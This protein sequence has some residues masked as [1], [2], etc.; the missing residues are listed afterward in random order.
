MAH[1]YKA[2]VWT[3]GIGNI[4]HCNDVED[5]SGISAK[6]WVPCRILQI[7][8]VDFLKMLKEKFN[9]I[10]FYYCEETNFIGW[11]F[12]S[13]KDAIAYKN[14][15]NKKARERSFIC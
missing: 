2:S 5:L 4:W 15:I 8:P 3:N 1:I 11:S 14:F 12:S 7:P 10:N 13:E 9:A 6:W